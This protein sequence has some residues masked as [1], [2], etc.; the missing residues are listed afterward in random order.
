MC[1]AYDYHYLLNETIISNNLRVNTGSYRNPLHDTAIDYAI[2]F[3]DVNKVIRRDYFFKQ[4]NNASRHFLGDWDFVMATAL[5]IWEDM[6]LTSFFHSFTTVL[7]SNGV[8]LN[9]A[10]SNTISPNGTI[11]NFKLIFSQEIP[12][13]FTTYYSNMIVNG[14]RFTDNFIWKNS[15]DYTQ[16]GDFLHCNVPVRYSLDFQNYYVN[17]LR[18]N[19][20][21]FSTTKEDKWYWSSERTYLDIISRDFQTPRAN[22]VNNSLVKKPNLVLR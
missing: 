18:D 14:Q 5:A 21:A 4:Q 13:N 22:P 20:F 6:R 17:S 12:A 10:F 8:I 1:C 11:F 3:N 7:Q 9:N 19:Y 15:R 2:S 16:S